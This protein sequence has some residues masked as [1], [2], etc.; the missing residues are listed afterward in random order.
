MCFCIYAYRLRICSI[1][2]KKISIEILFFNFF[3]KIT[4]YLSHPAP[5]NPVH[6]YVLSSKRMVYH[7][8]F[9]RINARDA[10]HQAPENF[11]INLP[12]GWTQYSAVVGARV[13]YVQMPNQ[14][15]NVEDGYNTFTY[16]SIASG[17]TEA[18]IT[19]TVS[20]GQ[21][22]F[23]ELTADLMSID[24]ATNGGVLNAITPYRSGTTTMF[25]DRH[26]EIQSSLA[27]RVS[28]QNNPLARALGFFDQS[29]TGVWTSVGSASNF[30]VAS[31]HPPALYGTRTV[32]V[33]CPELSF[34]YGDTA[35]GGFQTTALCHVPMDVPFGEVK[36]QEYGVPY[37]IRFPERSLH[38]L[39]FSLTDD[40]N[41]L[42]KFRGED[43]S[44][45][46]ELQC[47]L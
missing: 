40:N 36:H 26:I 6:I 33:H 10:V 3:K 18:I 37:I 42:I 13:I 16:T 11:R 15:Y 17:G 19:L 22:T 14:F 29:E 30:S 38:S 2:N 46:L 34:N 32:F 21:Y 28:S 9:L 4:H 23:E 5:L 44:I 1:H 35:S 8:T 25:A 31:P 27:I 47:R 45:I 41:N 7:S 12:G 20:P 43:W 24:N 39:N